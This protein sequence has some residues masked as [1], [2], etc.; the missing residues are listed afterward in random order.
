VINLPL[1]E[2]FGVEVTKPD[3]RIILQ[4]YDVA[5]PMKKV[6]YN[7]ILMG[8]QF[9]LTSSFNPGSSNF[10]YLLFFDS[11]ENKFPYTL[12]LKDLNF[13]KIVLETQ[14]IPYNQWRVL[15]CIE[16]EMEHK[17]S[18]TNDNK[19]G[20][21]SQIF[22]Y[23]CIL[24]ERQNQFIIEIVD[25]ESLQIVYKYVSSPNENISQVKI[26]K[27]KKSK[28]K[29]LFIGSSVEKSRNVFYSKWKIVRM[30]FAKAK[31]SSENK[32]FDIKF[33]EL[34]DQWSQDPNKFITCIFF[35]QD[36]LFFC[37]ENK[38][39]QIENESESKKILKSYTFDISAIRH[40][41]SWNKFFILVG[42]KNDIIVGI[43]AED[44]T[45]LQLE[46]KMRLQLEYLVKGI[47]FISSTD[48]VR[49]AVLGDNNVLVIYKLILKNYFQKSNV[50]LI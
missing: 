39:N 7:S 24:R 13:D 22:K 21:S 46:P 41:I 14:M 38:I 47:C 16:F 15:N 49:F 4:K 36:Y 34:E 17:F 35:K 45:I 31:N 11:H 1:Y 27:V 48:Q 19:G 37:F 9:C 32:K 2:S 42:S 43:W 23:I 50:S 18:L 5:I 29:Q 6:I 3:W 25:V 30:I 12:F 28:E 26:I 10:Q 40:Y 8:Q 20:L 44:Q 33:W